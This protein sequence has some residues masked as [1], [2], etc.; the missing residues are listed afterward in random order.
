MIKKKTSLT[1][2]SSLYD[3]AKCI[4]EANEKSSMN[5]PELVGLENGT[6]LIP[7]YD[8]KTFLDKYFKDLSLIKSK[9]HIR[10]NSTDIGLVYTKEYHDSEEQSQILLKNPKSLPLGLPDVIQPP[11]LSTARQDYLYKEIR[12]FCKE[13]NIWCAHVLIFKVDF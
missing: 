7:T 13:E 6:V 12:E 9:H 10:T 11:G 2:L 3:I 8:W 1:Y 4:I 5:Y